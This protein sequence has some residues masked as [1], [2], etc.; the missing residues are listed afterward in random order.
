MKL[1]SIEKI[2]AL[3]PI[4]G[5]GRIELAKVLG[6]QTVV[7]KGEFKVGDEC[8]W[9]FPD[10][11]VDANN[12]VY[13]FLANQGFRIKTSK[14]KGV[15]SQGLA[16][17]T[18][19]FRALLADDEF[20][21]GGFKIGDD[22]SNI[23]KISKYEKPLPEGNEAL[24]HFPDFLSKTDEPNLL[25]KPELL[26]QFIGK[27]CYISLKMDGQSGTYFLNKGRF[28]VCSRNLELRDTPGSP[29]WHMARKYDIQRT[30]EH[31]AR[32]QKD[33]NNLIETPDLAV[34]G[35]VYGPGIQGNHMG[36]KE[37]ELA[38]F[39]Q[40]NIG[41]HKYVDSRYLF[42]LCNEYV[43]PLVPVLWSDEFKWTLEGLQEFANKQRYANGT[44]AEGIVIRPLREC[45]TPEG[46]RLSAKVISQTFAAKY[47]E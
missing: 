15:Y 4:A 5:A 6:Y 20:Y 30:L 36:A 44:P 16:L 8:I 34:Q 27:F 26:E 29:F 23:I 32:A 37:K 13:S 18:D 31:Y 24:G 33:S 45:V 17:T 43:L 11:I 19:P 12:P 9:H 38:I 10:T 39:N 47:G 2:T 3:T 28:G 40:F 1:A 14:F 25:S 42:Q 22:V 7:K 35:E 41:S 21:S 46:E